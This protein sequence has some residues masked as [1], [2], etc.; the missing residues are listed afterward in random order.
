[1]LPETVVDMSL[2]HRPEFIISGGQTGVDRA[3]LDVALALAIDHGGFCPRGRRAEDGRID[4]R[5]Q[6]V[7]TPTDRYPE[8]TEKNV[9]SSDATLIVHRGVLTAG[10]AFTRRLATLHHCPCFVADVDEPDIA[11]RI[12]DWLAELQPKRLNIAGP[13]ESSVPGI[14]D[15]TVR[16]LTELWR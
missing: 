4:A 2:A 3:A 10:T 8:R 16:L 1:M 15:A 5:Y 6:L 9:R 12:A 14:H 11:D 7:E 13:R